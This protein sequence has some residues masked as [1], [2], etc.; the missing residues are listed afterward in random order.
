[1]NRHYIK[2]AL[3]VAGFAAPHVADAATRTG[4]LTVSV[5]IVDD[6]CHTLANRHGVSVSC[7]RGTAYAVHMHPMPTGVQPG[8]IIREGKE[9]DWVVATVWY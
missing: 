6:G 5:T 7:G 2:T 8:R 3:I 4:T 1:M 9:A